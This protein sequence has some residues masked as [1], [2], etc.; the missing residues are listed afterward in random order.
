MI[1]NVS[2][3]LGLITMNGSFELHLAMLIMILWKV[4][5]VR[6]PRMPLDK[7]LLNEEEMPE[8]LLRNYCILL[9]SFLLLSTFMYRSHYFS[10]GIV[11]QIFNFVGLGIYILV[12]SKLAIEL[13]DA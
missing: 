3:L 13:Y 6:I 7:N 1:V 12:I 5:K 4:E 11:L 2:T 10:N 9:H 8:G